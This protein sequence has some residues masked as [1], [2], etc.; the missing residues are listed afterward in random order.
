MNTT[1]SIGNDVTKTALYKNK[2]HNDQLF[3]FDGK[4]YDTGIR[5]LMHNNRMNLKII[6]HNLKYT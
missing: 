4:S 3:K 5:I 6:N 1:N 2:W